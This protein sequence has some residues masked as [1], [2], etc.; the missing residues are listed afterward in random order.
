MGDKGNGL[1]QD[2]R[3]EEREGGEV[4]L[5]RNGTGIN[6]LEQQKNRICHLYSTAESGPRQKSPSRFNFFILLV[7]STE[8]EA[9]SYSPDVI[10]LS[11]FHEATEAV[12]KI[13]G[14]LRQLFIYFWFSKVS[15]EDPERFGT[16]AALDIR[17]RKKLLE[18]VLVVL[19]TLPGLEVNL[20]FNGGKSC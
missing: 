12:K 13:G 8:V 15:N 5:A 19:G 14:F 3:T 1:S 17:A 16:T 10:V 4:Y 18:V 11:M 9:G 20:E 7:C 2:Y 6:S